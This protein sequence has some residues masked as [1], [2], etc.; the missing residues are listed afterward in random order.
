MIIGTISCANRCTSREMIARTLLVWLWLAFLKSA[1][2][3]GESPR[4]CT[5][6]APG[7]GIKTL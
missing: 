2:K 5:G 3:P 7:H 6:I 4:V 1:A